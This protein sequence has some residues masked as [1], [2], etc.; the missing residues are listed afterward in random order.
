MNYIAIYML[1]ADQQHVFKPT[2]KFDWFIE[3][4]LLPGL[5]CHTRAVHWLEL[6]HIVVK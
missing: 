4:A 6:T 5:D 2:Y 3:T 1:L